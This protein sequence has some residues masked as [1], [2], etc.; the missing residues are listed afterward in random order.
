MRGRKPK[1]TALKLADGTR[2]GRVNTAEPKPSGRPKMP[3]YLDVEARAE[4]RRIVPV[5]E[6]MKIL[7]AADAPLLALYC[8]AH[9]DYVG[10]T[11][12]LRKE[13][14][15]IETATGAMKPSP[16]LH[17]VN[18]AR[19]EMVKILAEFG[20]SPSSRSRLNVGVGSEVDALDA[21]LKRKT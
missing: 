20:C 9:S 12:A 11:K 10:A 7:G 15:V 4:W 14:K 2:P 8:Q 21:F 13:G 17:I 1:P 18:A 16:H 6:K 19:S 3:T 5:L